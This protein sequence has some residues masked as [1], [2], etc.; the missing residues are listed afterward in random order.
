MKTISFVVFFT[1]LFTYTAYAQLNFRLGAE[2]NFLVNSMHGHTKYLDY[3]YEGHLR[4][5]HYGMG[6]GYFFLK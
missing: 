5:F 1:I 6:V 4:L 3:E 2:A